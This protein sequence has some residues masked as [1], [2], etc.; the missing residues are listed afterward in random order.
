MGSSVGRLTSAFLTNCVVA[1]VSVLVRAAAGLMYPILLPVLSHTSNCSHCAGTL[2]T[3]G[4]GVAVEDLG[5]VVLVGSML[6][7]DVTTRCVVVAVDVGVM[8]CLTSLQTLAF[9]TVIGALM[10]V[11][12]T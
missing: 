8:K 5:A 10:S 3:G 7:S 6:V 12:S 4:C 1:L 9:S 11:E 2:L